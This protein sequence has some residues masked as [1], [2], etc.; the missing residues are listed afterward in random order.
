MKKSKKA[1]E[2]KIPNELEKVQVFTALQSVERAQAAKLKNSA[3]FDR[4]SYAADGGDA[5]IDPRKRELYENPRGKVDD[6]LWAKAKVASQAAFGKEKWQFM[7]WFYLKHGGKFG[8][9]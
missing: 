2:A 7:V 1:P 3:A 8:Q 5:W 4:A 9:A 6:A